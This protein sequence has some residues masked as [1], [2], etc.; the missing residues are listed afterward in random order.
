[1]GGVALTGPVLRDVR[2]LDAICVTD[3]KKLDLA[4]QIC[5]LFLRLP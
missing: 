1:M 5:K 4:L 2:G 3:P